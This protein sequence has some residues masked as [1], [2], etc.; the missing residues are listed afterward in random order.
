MISFF[1]AL[2]KTAATNANC[3]RFCPVYFTERAA[4]DAYGHQ[5][6]T[7][8]VENN[9]VMVVAFPWIADYSTTQIFKTDNQPTPRVPVS[10]SH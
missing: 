9:D 2:N 6:V 3:V 1:S 4:R 5:K 10:L 7:L 8:G